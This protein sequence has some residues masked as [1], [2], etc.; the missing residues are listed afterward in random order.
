M[1]SV[2]QFYNLIPSLTVFENGSAHHTDVVSFVSRQMLDCVAPSN[3]LSTNPVAQHIT[4]E[5][6]GRTL[7]NG[8]MRPVEDARRVLTRSTVPVTLRPGKDVAITPGKVVLSNPLIE[9]LRYDPMTPTVH[10]VP[11]LIVPAWIMKYYILDLSP[12][13]SLVRYLVEPGH[14]V[15]MISW[16]NPQAGDHDLSLEDY[17]RLGVMA[18]I[19]AIVERDGAANVNACGYCLGGTLLAIAAAAIARQGDKRHRRSLAPKYWSAGCCAMPG[20]APMRFSPSWMAAPCGSRNWPMPKQ[21]T[22]PSRPR[23]GMQQTVKAARLLSP[24]SRRIRMDERRA[25]A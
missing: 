12:A 24:C 3:F 19:D 15:Y 13:N 18:T 10:E 9:L 25:S 8:A 1:G 22:R 14:T 17:R 7:I 11:V 2:F 4:I 5:S 6:T 20:F 21:P 23:R 16:K